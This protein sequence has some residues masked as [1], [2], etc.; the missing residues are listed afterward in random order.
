MPEASNYGE[1]LAHHVEYLHS[2]IETLAGVL[3]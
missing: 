2:G 3:D 1:E